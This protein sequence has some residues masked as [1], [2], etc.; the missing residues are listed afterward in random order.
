MFSTP[1]VGYCFFSQASLIIPRDFEGSALGFLVFPPGLHGLCLQSSHFCNFPRILY[2]SLDV[3]FPS[4]WRKKFNHQFAH[5][6][7]FKYEFKFSFSLRN[8]LSM[9][10]HF[11]SYFHYSS[12]QNINKFHIYSVT[13]A[14]FRR[15]LPVKHLGFFYSSRCYISNHISWLPLNVLCILTSYSVL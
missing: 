3:L 10:T 6:F 7:L 12:I 15:T 2:L 1:D 11:I 8:I 5:F 9:W 4:L 13:H 14:L